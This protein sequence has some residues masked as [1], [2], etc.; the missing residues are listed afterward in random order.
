MRKGIQHRSCKEGGRGMNMFKGYE[1]PFAHAHYFKGKLEVRDEHDH[2]I[3]VGYS[4]P[5]NGTS[6]DQHF[7]RIEGLTIEE[8]GHQ[9]RFSVQSGPPIPL[10]AGGHYHRL[11]GETV[12]VE[13]HSHH[14]WGRTGLPLGNYP[15]NW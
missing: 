2:D 4:F 3:L 5:V 6:Y 14:F 10:P 8:N 7:H 9:H 1:L 11:E 15:P 12:S 13:N